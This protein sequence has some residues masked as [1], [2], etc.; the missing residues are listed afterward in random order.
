MVYE[1]YGALEEGE[2]GWLRGLCA[3]DIH[4]AASVC[5]SPYWTSKFAYRNGH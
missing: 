2:E 5:L 3:S 1:S 4:R